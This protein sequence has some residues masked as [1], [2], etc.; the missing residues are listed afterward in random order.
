MNDDIVLS[1][2][3]TIG[4]CLRRVAS[5]YGA[6]PRRLEDLDAQDVIVLNLQRSCEAAIDLTMHVVAEMRI[7]VPS[8][9]RD[10]FEM[11]RRE[12][13]LDTPLATRVKK[14]VGFRNVAV[15]DYQV[16]D[17][18]IRQRVIE[19]DATELERFG[20]TVLLM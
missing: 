12:G 11:L 17:L 8:D 2:V 4:R 15:H 18:A 6:E 10:A 14:M 20:E 1:K 19:V 9:A 16:I 7:G 13:L 3:S 5:K